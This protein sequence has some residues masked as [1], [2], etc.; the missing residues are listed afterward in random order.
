M[1][2][3]FME[4]NR[5]QEYLLPP[6]LQEWLPE[7]DLAWFVIDAVKQMELKAFYQKYRKDGW[8]AASYNPEMMV[9]LLLYAYSLGQRSSRKIEQLCERDIGFRVVSANTKVDHSTICRFRQ[10]NEKELEKLFTEILKLCAR[11]GLVKVGLV[12]IDGTKIKANAALSANRTSEHIE[13]EV[14]K[15]LKEAQARDEEED[16]LYGKEKRGDE[17]PPELQKRESRIKRL[18]ECKKRLDEEAEA[19]REKQQKKIEE[20]KKEEASSGQKKRGRKPVT[21]EEKVNQKAKAN[22]TDPDSRIMKNSKGYVQGYNGQAVVTEQQIIIAAELTQE[23]NDVKQ[24]HPMLE[25]A[26]ENL[27]EIEIEE[28]PEICLGDAGYW[29]KANIDSSGEGN[30]ELIIATSKDWKQRKALQEQPPPRGRIPKGLSERE[31]MERKLRTKR[32]RAL[33]KKRGI[34][35]EPVFGQ[36]KTARGIDLF[37]RRGLAA[38]A[39]EWK[40]ICATHNLLKLFRYGGVAWAC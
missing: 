33:Y 21:P 19:D 23:E 22:V 12:G 6:S 32:G 10:K 4:C 17:L 9:I 2:Y 8:G 29:S 40:L 1:G 39:S 35:P 34:I 26:Q 7:K 24:L 14:K 18:Q 31:L 25:K 11:A 28:S 16:K 36:I 3:N 30:P 15:W 13:E 38:C 5:E 27:K 20:R 37:L